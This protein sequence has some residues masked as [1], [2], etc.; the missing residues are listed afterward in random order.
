MDPEANMKEQLKLAQYIVDG[1]EGKTGADYSEAMEE[2]GMRL[3]ELVVAL[4]E[5]KEKTK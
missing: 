3:A 5:W 4:H 2:N 1:S